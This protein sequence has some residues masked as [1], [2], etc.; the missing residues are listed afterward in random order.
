MT[1]PKISLTGRFMEVTEEARAE[2]LNNLNRLKREYGLSEND[3]EKLKTSTRKL[4][5]RKQIQE[6]RYVVEECGDETREDLLEEV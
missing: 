6:D 2:I 1:Q 5:V 3:L 4:F